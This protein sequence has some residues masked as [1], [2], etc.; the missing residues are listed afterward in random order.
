[1]SGSLG[2]EAGKWRL[3]CLVLRREGLGAGVVEGKHLKEESCQ[4]GQGA[5]GTEGG[6]SL[7]LL[8]SLLFFIGCSCGLISV[9]EAPQLI[10]KDRDILNNGLVNLCTKANS[11]R[12]LGSL[13]ENF[14]L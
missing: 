9:P 12:Y 1:M 13:T 4:M 10:F 7:I 14:S 8:S 11:S 5:P 6:F 3:H 2:G